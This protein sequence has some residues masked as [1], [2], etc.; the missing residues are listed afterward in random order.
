MIKQ[1][2]VSGPEREWGITLGKCQR[3]MLIAKT[4]LNSHF[5]GLQ[6]DCILDGLL[7]GYS[8]PDCSLLLIF[9]V[10]RI[11]KEVLLCRCLGLF[12]SL[13][14]LVLVE[15]GGRFEDLGAVKLVGGSRRRFGGKTGLFCG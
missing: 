3:D 14:C 10:V 4:R 15:G 8:Q 2:L 6:A 11:S 12:G 5:V 1:T 7:G 9:G 13:R